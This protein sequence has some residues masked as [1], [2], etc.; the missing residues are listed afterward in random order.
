MICVTTDPYMV[1]FPETHCVQKRGLPV[2]F[3]ELE[4]KQISICMNAEMYPTID[5]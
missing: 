3:Q 1:W 2:L 5:H 4:M